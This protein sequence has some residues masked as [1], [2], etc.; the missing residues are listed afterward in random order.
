L[1]REISSIYS[2][3]TLN[4]TAPPPYGQFGSLL[5]LEPGLLYNS[6]SDLNKTFQMQINLVGGLEVNLSA[7]DMIHPLTGLDTSGIPALSEQNLS[8]VSIYDEAGLGSASV[9]GRVFL[10]KAGDIIPHGQIHDI[11]TV[12]LSALYVC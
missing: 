8:E 11:L 10:S 7:D 6:T 3:K 5:D 9:L 2:L 1:K 4:F 12:S